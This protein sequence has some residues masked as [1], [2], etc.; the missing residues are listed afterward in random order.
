MENTKSEKT[1]ETTLMKKSWY[2]KYYL[3]MFL[4]PILIVIACLIYLAFFYSQTNSLF[5]KDVSL[6]GGTTITLSGDIDTDALESALKQEYSN[7]NFRKLTNLGYK[8]KYVYCIYGYSRYCKVLYASFTN[9]TNTK[10]NILFKWVKG[11]GFLRNY[12]VV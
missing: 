10:S 9:S 8:R 11:M 3:I 6:S 12:Y 7:I 5:Y 1:A 2:D 4:I